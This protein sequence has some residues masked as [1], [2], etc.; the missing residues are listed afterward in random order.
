M[1]LAEGSTTSLGQ[2]GTFI[3]LIIGAIGLQVNAWRK[4]KSDT[5]IDEANL[6]LQS[7]QRDVLRQIE[8]GQALQNGK[9]ANVVSVNEAH[10][11]ELIRSLQVTCRAQPVV[12]QQVNKPPQN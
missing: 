11:A 3:V 7:E 2:W 12:I 1:L 8:K 5:K 10:H 6:I 4:H 9:L